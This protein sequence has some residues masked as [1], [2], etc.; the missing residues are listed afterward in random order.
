M[1]CLQYQQSTQPEYLCNSTRPYMT[2]SQSEPST[3]CFQ[4]SGPCPVP[5]VVTSGG[6]VSQ[7]LPTVPAHM[8]FLCDVLPCPIQSSHA[9]K[10]H[11]TSRDIAV[12]HVKA[13]VPANNLPDE[14]IC[15]R[16][17]LSQPAS[18][19]AKEGGGTSRHKRP[20]RTKKDK[21]RTKDSDRVI[22]TTKQKKS[23]Y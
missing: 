14:P 2:A 10:Q 5:A 22:T 12:S 18:S 20:E 13:N 17:P 16:T 8:H 9:S 7:P 3:S 6:S 4:A 21:V 19:E 15:E 1:H 11:V 23:R